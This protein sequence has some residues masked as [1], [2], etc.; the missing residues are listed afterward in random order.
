MKTRAEVTVEAIHHLLVERQSNKRQTTGTPAHS[1]MSVP[2]QIGVVRIGNI[3]EIA[4]CNGI[5]LVPILIGPT[6]QREPITPQPS[7]PTR[8]DRPY[9]ILSA[10]ATEIL[11]DKKEDNSREKPGGK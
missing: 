7:Q 5:D 4:K 8:V 9:I 6:K 3:A 10:T 11:N 1:M 2:C